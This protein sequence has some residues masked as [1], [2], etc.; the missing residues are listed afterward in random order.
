MPIIFAVDDACG[1]SAHD[2][3]SEG[4]GC[5]A[6]RIRQLLLPDLAN[7]NTQVQQNAGACTVCGSVV[8]GALAHEDSRR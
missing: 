3:H 8:L 2:L 4:C 6:Y 5:R 1:R 7:H